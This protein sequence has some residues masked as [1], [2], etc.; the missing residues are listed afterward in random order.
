M[1][2][3]VPS[4]IVLRSVRSD[5][6]GKPLNRVGSLTRIHPGVYAP[7]ARWAALRP[8]DRYL[9]RVHA[10][11]LTRPDAVFCFESA[12][13]LHGL[14]IFGEPRH[15]HILSEWSE[16]HSTRS[17][18]VVFHK[19]HDQREHAI[20]AAGV[21]V[22]IADTVLDLGRILPP[23]FALAVADAAL[24]RADDSVTASA[25]LE[26]ARSQRWRRGIRQLEWVLEN[27]DPLAESA[28]E[29]V[30]RATIGWLGYAQP[31]LQVE[32]SYEGA[33]DRVDFYW[34]RQRV[35][36]ESDG[37]G[38]YRTGDIATSEARLVSEK[39]REDRL[40]RH[41]QGFVRWDFADAL[42]P[43]RLDGKLRAGGLQPVRPQDAR[44]LA[45]LRSNPRSLRTAG[46][47]PS[48]GSS[49]NS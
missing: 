20:S 28:A 17:G 29:S 43:E 45:T 30:G 22:G 37:Y 5:S 32:F 11:R 14:P 48:T 12:A 21:A 24:R 46:S 34:R 3:F 15:V 13:V 26:R 49:R 25:L 1:V 27:T 47:L 8:W 6:F 39:L 7:K 31:E 18:D 4:P 44:M 23:A 33:H 36:G 9:A 2:A 19:F 40:R 10:T 41:E 35:I 38:K 42:R 16:S